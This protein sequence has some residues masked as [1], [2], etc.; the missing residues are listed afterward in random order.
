MYAV[1][2]AKSLIG[3]ESELET[4]KEF[5]ETGQ[6]SCLELTGIFLKIHC[7]LTMNLSFGCFYVVVFFLTKIFRSTILGE[8]FP[9]LQKTCHGV[10][11]TYLIVKTKRTCFTS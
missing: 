7:T 8:T 6:L 5:V 3:R 10:W 2:K 4:L 11:I 1:D 9:V